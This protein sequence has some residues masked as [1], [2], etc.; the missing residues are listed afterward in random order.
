MN[1]LKSTIFEF[2]H[3]ERGEKEIARSLMPY[4]LKVIEN[5]KEITLIVLSENI[6][7][8]KLYEYFGFK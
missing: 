7:A 6:S 8:K 4:V 5:N 3:A 2:W 1:I